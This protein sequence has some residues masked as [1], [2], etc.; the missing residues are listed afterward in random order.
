MNDYELNLIRMGYAKRLEE[1]L[2]FVPGFREK[3]ND[4]I[5]ETLQE[6]EF[7]LIPREFALVD[8]GDY[9]YVRYPNS[10]MDLYVD[11]FVY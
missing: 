1:C 10:A 4:N 3:Y 2:T 7:P 11:F 9:F 6:Y 5:A 8:F